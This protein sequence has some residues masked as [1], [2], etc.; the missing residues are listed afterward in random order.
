MTEK[1]NAMINALYTP[2]N[3][4]KKMNRT[5]DRK[6][7]KKRVAAKH[8]AKYRFGW[9]FMS[10]RSKSRSMYGK[11]RLNLT[12]AFMNRSENFKRTLG[13]KKEKGMGGIFNVAIVNPF[14]H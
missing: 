7:N 10:A 9:T 12:P 6:I 8:M 11:A 3:F 2:P 13:G 5:T 14:V 1:T 4:R